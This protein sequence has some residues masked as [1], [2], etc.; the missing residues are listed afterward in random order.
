M[1]VYYLII[2]QVYQKEYMWTVKNCQDPETHSC[3]DGIIELVEYRI[4]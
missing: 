4:L 2:Y 1:K 3:I